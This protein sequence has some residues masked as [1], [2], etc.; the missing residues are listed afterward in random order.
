MQE[1]FEHFSKRWDSIDIQI[2]ALLD[3][4]VNCIRAQSGGINRH[5]FDDEGS[6]VEMMRSNTM[7]SVTRDTSLNNLKN[8]H[9]ILTEFACGTGSASR[10]LNGLSHFLVILFSAA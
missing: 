6:L 8:E 4:L 10:A 3:D 9:K 5:T 1:A 2:A 7:L